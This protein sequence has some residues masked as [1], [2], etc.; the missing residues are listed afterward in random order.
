MTATLTETEPDVPAD[1]P[2][3]TAA[4]RCQIEEVF[5]P[6]FIELL[7]LAPRNPIVR[8]LIL[9]QTRQ[10]PG[11]EC[12][13]FEQLKDW[14]ETTCN[15]RIPAPNARATSAGAGIDITVEFSETENGRADY[16]VTRSGRDTFQ[17]GAETLLEIV[18]DAIESGGGLDEVVD[19]LADKIEDDAWSQCN[20]DLDNY[21]DYDYNDHDSTGSE[22]RETDY[23]KE[24]IRTAVLAFVRERHPEL[25]AEL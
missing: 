10:Q 25:A 18:Q 21:G 13:T 4:R 3:L 7:A 16:S 17:V 8:G 12:A 15:K 19:L 6:P 23:S 9:A 22:D 1:V 14:V 24:D 2:V 11:R 5:C 20:P